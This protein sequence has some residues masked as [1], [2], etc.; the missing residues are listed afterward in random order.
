[1]DK[2]RK[3]LITATEIACWEYCPGQCRPCGMRRHCGQ[4]RL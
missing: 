4:A 3:E 1:M 2:H